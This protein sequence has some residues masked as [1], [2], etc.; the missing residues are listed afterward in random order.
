M[1]IDALTISVNKNYADYD[2]FV[3]RNKMVLGDLMIE[4]Q[5]MQID[6]KEKPLNRSP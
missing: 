6:L 5:N 2:K 1:G 3:K 4:A